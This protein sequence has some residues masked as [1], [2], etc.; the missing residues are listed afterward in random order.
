MERTVLGVSHGVRDP[1]ARFIAAPPPFCICILPLSISR[2]RRSALVWSFDSAVS[3][4]WEIL[5]LFFPLSRNSTIIHRVSARTRVIAWKISTGGRVDRTFSYSMYFRAAGL[6][7]AR[8]ISR[9][10]ATPRRAVDGYVTSL[11]FLFYFYSAY[12]VCF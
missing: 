1:A 12:P 7:R 3:S 11:L 5:C 8:K 4:S 6:A 9:K 10:G 2:S